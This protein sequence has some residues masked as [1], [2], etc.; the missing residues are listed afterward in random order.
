M[1]DPKRQKKSESLEVRLSYAAKQAFVARCRQERSSASEV[2]RRFIDDYLAT[3]VVVPRPTR[4]E[5]SMTKLTRYAHP[6]FATLAGLAVAGLLT[7]AGI[8]PTSA[9]PDLRATF[10]DLDADDDGQVTLEEYLARA[11]MDL[12]I[13]RQDQAGAGAPPR[14]FMLPIEGPPP[15]A[16]ALAPGMTVLPA[17]KD[18]RLT[19]EFK[20]IDK[21]ASGGITFAEFVARHKAVARDAW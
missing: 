17:P 18:H 7:F 1:T 13:N 10:A 6:A 21:D 12:F 9:W 14:P 11:R 19:R 2:V 20:T 15:Q 16:E 5:I 8:T 3:P 4:S